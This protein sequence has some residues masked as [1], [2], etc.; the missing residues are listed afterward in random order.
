MCEL[1]NR[2][3]LK[4]ELSFFLSLE[5]DMI[6]VKN[7][8]LISFLFLGISHI[9][10]TLKCFIFMAMVIVLNAYHCASVY[11]SWQY[12]LFVAFVY[13]LKISRFIN[14][15]YA[16]MSNSYGF[17]EQEFT[18]IVVMCSRSMMIVR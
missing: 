10:C 7:G 2:M 14:Y 3:E 18:R 6:A 15:Y 17:W 9:L 4:S 1:V 8:M 16:V 5:T 12:N 11:N 13:W